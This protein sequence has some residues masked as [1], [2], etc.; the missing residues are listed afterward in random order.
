MQTELP[1]MMRKFNKSPGLTFIGTIYAN[2]MFMLPGKPVISP[3]RTGLGKRQN[4]NSL[5]VGPFLEKALKDV[6]MI[7]MYHGNFGKMLNK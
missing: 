2:S 1:E 5:F 7:S 6:S 4:L 3:V